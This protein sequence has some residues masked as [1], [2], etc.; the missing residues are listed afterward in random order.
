MEILRQIKLAVAAGRPVC[1]WGTPGVGKTAIVAQLAAELGAH[2]EVVIGSIHEPSDFSGLPIP[3]GQGG[4][5]LAPPA[6]ARRIVTAC[7]A[8]RRAV[9]FL[10][11][12]STAP[13][14][15]Q[16][17]LLRV[18][19]ER[20]V[21]DL[22]LPPATIIIAAANPPECAAGGWDMALP[23]AGR[24]VQISFPC[25]SA[26]E[27]AAWM[28]GREDIHPKARALATGFVRARPALL[29][30]EMGKVSARQPLAYASPR[31]HEAAARIVGAALA[32]GHD[33]GDLLPLIAGALGEP[34]AIEYC[35]WL[36]SADLPDPEAVLANPASWTPDMRKPDV[37]F[38]TLAAVA[39][40]STTP[41][42]NRAE[43]Q[44]RWEAAVAVFERGLAA[45]KEVVL[46]PARA[47][48]APAA[49]PAAMK[50][51]APAVV[52]F[53]SKISEVTKAAGIV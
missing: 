31:S 51:L 6:W 46:I 37:I 39:A 50:T 19:H 13:P 44:R 1:L 43:Y 14:A 18:V 36:R 22:A 45:G 52:A 20:V 33:I 9:L 34:V 11:E 15:V 40:A 30:E 27:W 10:D 21:G 25:P 42:P 29:A 26:D 5:A 7:A 32:A 28:L 48:A 16:A 41:R 35:A 53:A 2:L 38:A 3:D 47:W 23:L 49:R 8:G 12:I 24:F 4:V 17:A